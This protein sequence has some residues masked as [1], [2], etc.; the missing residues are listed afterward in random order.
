M[1]ELGADVDLAALTELPDALF[2]VQRGRVQWANTAA[3]SLLGAKLVDR[4]FEE[5][6][7]PGE[8][9]RLDQ[10]VRHR[11][12]GWTMPA[13]C[14]LRFVRVSDGSEITADVRFGHSGDALVLSARDVTAITRAEALMGRL[15]EMFAR[16]SA[17]LDADELL[18]ATSSLFIALGW[19]VAFTEILE[20]GR[21]ITRRVIS[22]PGD[23]VGEYGRS[24]IDV[25]LPFERTPIL[26]EVVRTGKPVFLDNLPTLLAGPVRKASALGASME[27]AQ[28]SCSAW[29]PVLTNGTLTHLLAITGRDVTEHDFVA[30]QLF[31]AHLGAAIH[32]QHLRSAL[33]HKERLA[34]LGEMAAVMAHEVRNPLGVVFNAIAGLRRMPPTSGNMPNLLDIIQ[35][36]AHRLQRLVVDLL[37]FSRPSL[38]ELRR[39][40]LA[41]LLRQAVDAARQDS[42]F[43]GNARVVDVDVPVGLPTVETDPLL[44]HRALVNLL[45]NALQNVAVDGAVSL[46]ASIDDRSLVVRVH[47]DG[48]PVAPEVVAHLFEPF[49]TTRPTGTGLGLAVVRRIADDLGGDVHVEPGERTGTTFALRLPLHAGDRERPSHA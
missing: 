47:N 7:A 31:A 34:A 14:R 15:A 49:F 30:I 29:C 46:V 32:M 12:S 16:G 3:T 24:I 26:A 43:Q 1:A 11:G 33:V 27:R 9:Q 19:V 41:P 39:T 21:S 17:L 5:L 35:Q 6:L 25:A 18:D 22:S 40:E 38:V 36:E 13:G 8:S 44:V 48:A 10:V 37:D 23:P 20:G 4:S 42:I 2:V 45:V 28:V